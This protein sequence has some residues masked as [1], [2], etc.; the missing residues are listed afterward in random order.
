M[1]GFKLFD[2]SPFRRQLGFQPAAD[3]IGVY[4]TL[5]MTFPPGLYMPRAV[6]AP[7]NDGYPWNATVQTRY[8]TGP[9]KP[10]GWDEESHG[11]RQRF[12]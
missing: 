5:W 2:A 1:A 3:P 12:Y 9:V 4:G 8:V 7:V 6:I 10:D 11:P